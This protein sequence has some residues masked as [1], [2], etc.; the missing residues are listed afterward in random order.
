VLVDKASEILEEEQMEKVKLK[1]EM[2]IVVSQ[3]DIDDIM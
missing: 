2:E 1:V 3:E